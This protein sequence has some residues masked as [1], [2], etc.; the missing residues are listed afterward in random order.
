MVN[1]TSSGRARVAET[2]N[3]VTTNEVGHNKEV[4]GT[5]SNSEVHS[6]LTF[7]Q[8][9]SENPTSPNKRGQIMD[10]SKQKGSKGLEK[11]ITKRMEYL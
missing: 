10:W 1:D 8:L 2:N 9:P 6:I 5:L 11:K 4:K 3:R 7:S